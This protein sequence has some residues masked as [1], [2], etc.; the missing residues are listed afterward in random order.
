[1]CGQEA[2]QESQIYVLRARAVDSHNGR[3][4]LSEDNNLDKNLNRKDSPRQELDKGVLQTKASQS[5][6]AHMLSR[7]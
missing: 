4:R 5:S 6:M 3:Y 2:G 7:G 1:M